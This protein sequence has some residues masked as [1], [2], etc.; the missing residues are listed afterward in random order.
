M[1]F[2]HTRVN[3]PI[4]KEQEAALA[5][6]FGEAISLLPGKSEQWLMLQFEE[7]CRLWFRGQNEQAQAFVQVQTFGKNN[8]SACDALTDRICSLLEEHLH[9]SPENIYVR[10]DETTLWGWNGAN[11]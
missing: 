6:A 9:I 11:F 7:N 2:I 4:A 10:Y 5:K 1:P 8:P 3:R